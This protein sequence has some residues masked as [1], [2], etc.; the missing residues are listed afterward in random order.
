[1]RFK[2]NWFRRLFRTGNDGRKTMD[3]RRIR[4][5]S[6]VPRPSS[7]VHRPSSLNYALFLSL[8]LLAGIFLIKTGILQSAPVTSTQTN[9]AG[10][11]D[12]GAAG[13]LTGWTKYS[14][15]D[16]GVAA[17]TDIQLQ[18][19]DYTAT[20]TSDTGAQATNDTTYGDTCSSVSCS[21]GGG[22]NAGT[23]TNPIVSGTATTASVKLLLNTGITSIDA[24]LTDPATLPLGA[25]R[26]VAFSPDNK[27]LAIAYQTTSPY[28]AVY[29]FD[30]VAGTI[31]AKL[32]DPATPPAGGAYGLA[33]SSDNKFLAV[34]HAASPYLTVYNFDPVAGTIGA[35]L[36]NPAT[37]PTGYGISLAFSSD[38]KFLAIAHVTSPFLTVYNFDPVAGTIGAKLANP[39]TLPPSD[40]RAIAFS[41]DDKFLVVTHAASPYF[42]VYNFDPVAGTIGAKLTDPATLPTGDSRGIA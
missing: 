27:F 32:T 17:G 37:M 38:D 11:L 34:T 24:K 9:W 13:T 36:A 25:G 23:K 8:A 2:M 33:F 30:P 1:M 40:G 42:T 10:G 19:S 18:S 22:F 6:L 14:A 7:L 16:T 15:K 5:S 31:G 35:K 39:A 4:P 26:K 29:N 41:S 3:E 21:I 20:Q 12:G 28:L